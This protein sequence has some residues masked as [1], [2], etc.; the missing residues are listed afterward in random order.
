MHTQDV[1]KILYQKYTRK[2]LTQ[3]RQIGPEKMLPEN[4][5]SVTD[6]L[7]CMNYKFIYIKVIF[8]R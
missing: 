8:T 7:F 4:F 2:M 3:K 1:M 5:I 6:T